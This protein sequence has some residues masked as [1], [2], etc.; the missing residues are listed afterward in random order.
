MSGALQQ[1]RQ[2]CAMRSAGALIALCLALAVPPAAS[3]AAP[4]VRVEAAGARGPVGFGAD[5]LSAAL[6][7]RGCRVDA[8]REPQVTVVAAVAGAA[9]LEDRRLPQAAGSFAIRY[10]PMSRRLHVTGRDA[11]GAMYGLLELAERARMGE[12]FPPTRAI[13]R[14]PYL[15]FRATNPFL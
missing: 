13:V 6:R 5:E 12:P 11:A 2:A 15:E 7:A 8:A 1:G 14:A 3:A 4:T 10:A 9:L